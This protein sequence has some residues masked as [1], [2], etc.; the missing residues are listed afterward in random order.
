MRSPEAVRE[1][2]PQPDKPAPKGSP[3]TADD[4]FHLLDKAAGFLL[5]LGLGYLVLMN[6]AS[7]VWVSIVLIV[8][9]LVIKVALRLF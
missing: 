5:V 3:E 8:V 9:G 1:T 4:A 2:G 7:A 6:L